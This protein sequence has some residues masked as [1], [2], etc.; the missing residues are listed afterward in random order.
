MLIALMGVS[1]A[2]LTQLALTFPSRIQI[3]SRYRRMQRFFS[4]HWINYND[5]AQFVMKLFGFIDTDFYLSLDRTNWKW[6]KININLQV[7]A[8]VYCGVYWLP[9]NK[10]G[11]SNSRER[12]ALLQ[13]FIDRLGKSRIKGLLA[14]RELIGDE[15]MGW[16]IKQRIPFFIRIRN[17]SISTNSQNHIT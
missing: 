9:L 10:R 5:I 17:N 4:E 11:N 8:V 14:D 1:T 2:N 13:R 15:W 12:M 7:L 3:P 6:D 16:L